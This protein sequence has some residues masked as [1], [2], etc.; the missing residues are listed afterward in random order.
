MV[1]LLLAGACLAGVPVLTASAA[2]T[3]APAARVIEL[4]GLGNDAAYALA[5][6][7]DGADLAVGASNG[8]YV[9]DATSLQ[10][11]T[12]IPADSWVRSLVYSRDGKLLGAGLFDNSAR[13]WQMPA[14]T[15][16]RTL[17]GF[18]GWVRSIAFSPDSDH[19]FTISDDNAARLWNLQDGSQ[20]LKLDALQGARVIALSPD[21]STLAIGM[22]D[23][24]IQLRRAADGSLLRLLTGHTGWVRSLAFSPDGTRLASGAF[25][26]TARIWN[27]SSGALEHTLLGHQSSVLAI[28]FSPDG[29][30]VATGS[31]DRTVKLWN[32]S[33][34]AVLHTLQG[35]T[36]F[37]YSLAFSPDGKSIAAGAS[38]NTVRIWDLGDLP[39]DTPQP[40]DTPH[41]CRACHH[42][43]STSHGPAIPQVRCDACHAGGANLNWCPNFTRST[44]PMPDLPLLSLAEKVAG[45]PVPG[46]SLAVSIASPANGESLY[47]A[48]TLA[49]PVTVA[50]HVESTAAPLEQVALQLDIYQGQALLTTLTKAPQPDGTFAFL[51]AVNPHG[52]MLRI[53]NPAARM[54]CASCH[55]DFNPEAYLPAGDLRLV[56]TA[57]TR[58]GERATDERRVTADVG[59]QKQLGVTVQDVAGKPIRGVVV[60]AVTKFYMWRGRTASGVSDASGLA[61]LGLEALSQAS[62]AY[63]VSVPMQVIDGLFYSGDKLAAFTVEPGSKPLAPVTVHIS[64]AYGQITGSLS[65]GA[66]MVPAHTPVNA[67][68][69]PSGPLLQTQ[70]GDDGQ[71]SFSQLRAGKYVVFADPASLASQD[72]AGSAQTVDLSG[73]P[74]AQVALALVP[75]ASGTLR[76]TL[77]AQD[78]GWLPFAQVMTP[79]EI[80]VAADELS[81]EWTVHTYST[82]PVRLVASAPGYYSSEFSISPSQADAKAIRLEARPGTQQVAWGSGTLTLPAETR[83]TLAQGRVDVQSGWLW[84]RNAASSPLLISTPEAEITL[85]QGRFALERASGQSAWL[86]LFDGQAQVRSRSTGQQVSLHAG[87]MLPL[88]DGGGWTALPYSPAMYQ[89]L[90]GIAGQGYAAVPRPT[91]TEQVKSW[92]SALGIGFAQTITFITYILAISSLALVPLLT[93]VWWFSAKSRKKESEQSNVQK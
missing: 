11:R 22:Q 78:G 4:P 23:N 38:D 45:V 29:R 56:V 81:G 18:D 25:D 91:L 47:S 39:A 2:R 33:D 16:L 9:Y 86:V 92:L 8:I 66:H 27:V 58:S 77:A 80:R 85:S 37:V 12:S 13:L 75:V 65:N 90:S 53:N 43:A 44:Q 20:Q 6:S 30:S 51:L 83:A 57:T 74:T 21:G 42:P 5:Y 71:F 19:L 36:S 3:P 69:L 62:V 7:P 31:V 55:D 28:S 61:S 10:P 70:A 50:G 32:T 24:T 63:E 72:L 17:T 35:H 34:G 67:Y 41:E 84:G 26:A 87:Q 88:A 73:S 49:A 48:A 93:L 68:K 89:V 46:Q 14:A 40:E 82:Q 79:E 64:A 54:N 1:L 15:P 59:T 52:N 76:G 60:H